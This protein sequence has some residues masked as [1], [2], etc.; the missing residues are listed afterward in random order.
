MK[1]AERI[2]KIEKDPNDYGLN[3]C[4][5]SST[6]IYKVV[7]DDSVVVYFHRYSDG[8]FIWINS[9][10]FSED[11]Q[12]FSTFSEL[13]EFFQNPND[14]TLEALFG[15]YC[16]SNRWSERYV[17]YSANGVLCISEG[18]PETDWYGATMPVI[19]AESCITREGYQFFIQED[20]SRIERLL[21]ELK[22]L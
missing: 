18:W 4:H 21:R 9:Q 20:G 11:V 16:H 2:F 8:D 17:D 3:Y 22:N 1:S 10:G 12:Y 5:Y 6:E 15:K 13:E 14:E 7:D 19:Q